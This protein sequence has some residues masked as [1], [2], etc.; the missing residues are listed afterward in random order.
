MQ[1]MSIGMTRSTRLKDS[2]ATE[3]FGEQL[4]RRLKGSEVVELI[5]DLGGGKTTL[6][7]GIARGAGSSD[8]VGSPTF[9]LSKVYKAI[10]YNIYHFDFYRLSE[11]GVMEHELHEV[12]E[13][14]QAVVIVEWGEGV[15]HVL[16]DNRLTIH[17]DKTSDN[18]RQITCTFPEELGYL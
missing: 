5:S 12:L 15:Q 13:S 11:A 8:V 1:H 2:D 9:M 6:T 18:S 14:P 16:P 17:I 7:R 3:K 4:G 10:K